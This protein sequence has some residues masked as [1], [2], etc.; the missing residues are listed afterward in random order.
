MCGATLPAKKKKR[1][2][3][4]STGEVYDEETGLYHLR[5]RYYDPSIGRFLN[6]DT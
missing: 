2:T 6:E 5:A 3:H 1:Q 4:S